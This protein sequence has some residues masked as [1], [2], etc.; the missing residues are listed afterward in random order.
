M[1]NQQHFYIKDSEKSLRLKCEKNPA[2]NKSKA[3]DNIPPETCDIINISHSQETL[4]VCVVDTNIQT[5]YL[6]SINVLQPA[7][8]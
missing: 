5:F 1:M 8:C 7:C 4:Q 2:E 6:C 3:P